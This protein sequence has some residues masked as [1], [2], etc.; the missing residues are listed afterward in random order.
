VRVCSP[1]PSLYIAVVLRQTHNLFTV[2]F[3]LGISVD[4]CNLL[5]FI[6]IY[7]VTILQQNKYVYNVV[8][9][10]VTVVISYKIMLV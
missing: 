9:V 3:N 8:V 4:Y 7:E 5:Y 2:G 10:V 6:I 1:C